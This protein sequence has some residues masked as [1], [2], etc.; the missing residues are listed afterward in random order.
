MQ[1]GLLVDVVLRPS[2]G[3]GIGLLNHRHQIGGAQVARGEPLRVEEHADLAAIPADQRG[4][5][6]LRDRLHR[7]V[8]LSS[9][10]TKHGMIVACAVERQ[11]ENRHVVDRARLDQRRT[12]TK[13]DAVEIRLQLLV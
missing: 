3:L 5:G 8:H 11:R 7:I 9:D 10:P 13:R 4:L 6:D 12:D 2:V 1:Q